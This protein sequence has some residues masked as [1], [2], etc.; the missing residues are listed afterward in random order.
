MT[1]KHCELNV[2]KLSRF[3]WFQAWHKRCFT[4]TK[5]NRALDSTTVNDG[6]D[7]DIYCKSCYSAQFGMKGYGYGQGAGTLMSVS[8]N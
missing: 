6:P 7:G 1:F 8:T 4:C 5:C 2:N 3:F